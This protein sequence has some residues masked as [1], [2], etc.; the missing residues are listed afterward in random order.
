MNKLLLPLV[1]LSIFA[2]PA[3]YAGQ[4]RHVDRDVITYKH[5]GQKTVV[6]SK[7]VSKTVRKDD[8]WKKSQKKWAKGKKL[9][10]WK[11]RQ[12]V[13]DYKRYRL[14]RPGYGQQWVRVG[15]DFLLIRIGTGII[16]SFLI[17]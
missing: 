1:A 4:V 7:H 15:N 3:A 8:H 9:D 2:A 13:H 6:K 16:A 12:V 17:R 14:N 10:G 5:N 11:N